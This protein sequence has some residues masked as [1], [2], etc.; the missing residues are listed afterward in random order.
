QRFHELM[1]Q[2]DKSAAAGQNVH[3]SVGH[4]DVHVG[5][6]SSDGP[7]DKAFNEKINQALAKNGAHAN[8]QSAIG[9]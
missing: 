6:T 9:G 8:S 5:G 7:M 4:M 2:D 3:I 1:Q